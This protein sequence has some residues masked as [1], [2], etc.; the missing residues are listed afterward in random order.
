MRPR[1]AF[2]YGKSYTSFEIQYQDI[3][4][5]K[6]HITVLAAVTNTGSVSGRQVVQLYAGV[7]FG[8]GSEHKR[9][10]AFGKT[11]LLNPGESETLSLSFSC[12]DLSVYDENKSAW[13]LRA[14]DYVLCLGSAADETEPVFRLVMEREALLEQCAPICPM[15]RPVAEITPPPRAKEEY[16]LPFAVLDPWVPESVFHTY[17]TPEEGPDAL[18]S[19]MT[20]EQLVNLVIG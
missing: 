17:D 4:L 11:G 9:L 3:L 7:P 14:G 5:Q 8:I 20:D 10:I 16:S 19:S 2:G 18:I 15:N 12:R 6:D 13:M 1:Y